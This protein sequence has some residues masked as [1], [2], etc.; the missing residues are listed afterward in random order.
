MTFR[1]LAIAVAIAAAALSAPTRAANFDLS[2]DADGTSR[3]YEYF[4]DVY[5]ELGRPFNGSQF[6]DG[7]FAISTDAQIGGGYNVFPFEGAFTDIGTLT[8]AAGTGVGTESV[9]VTGLTMHFAP[10]I[11]PDAT[12]LGEGVN[13]TT[14][15]SGITGTAVLVDGALAS[16]DL[17]AAI[18]FTYDFSGIG[19]GELPFEGTFVIDGGAFTLAV[20]SSYPSG[21]DDPLRYR[22]DATGTVRGL[23]GVPN[24]VIPEPSS[25]ALMAAGL[26]GVAAVARRR[27]R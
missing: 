22:W 7:F 12:F 15:L 17:V 16:I 21:F 6:N 2:L 25:V 13:Y 27:A 18:A 20:D 5:G 10:F 4:S 8:T 3:W 23:V 19:A 14:T 26:I 9:A 1:P 24:P 11:A